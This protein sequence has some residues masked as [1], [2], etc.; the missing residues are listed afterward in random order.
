MAV[1]PISVV[2]PPTGPLVFSEV[3]IWFPRACSAMIFLRWG[4]T[5]HTWAGT[6][7]LQ[8]RSRTAET[9]TERRDLRWP[10]EAEKPLQIGGNLRCPCEAEDPLQRGGNL[11]C[12]SFP[13]VKGLRD[14]YYK[15]AKQWHKINPNFKYDQTNIF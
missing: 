14:V 3:C 8:G 6:Q 13:R 11:R 10:W 4:H 2:N 1:V 5:A 7:S 15:P 9:P 12:W